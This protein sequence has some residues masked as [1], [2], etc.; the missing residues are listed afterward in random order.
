MSEEFNGVTV[1]G[2]QPWVHGVYA[3]G[4]SV[5]VVD[6]YLPDL[7]KIAMSGC[8]GSGCGGWSPSQ[9]NPKCK[10][11]CEELDDDEYC[12]KVSSEAQERACIKRKRASDGL[13]PVCGEKGRFVNFEMTCSKHGPYTCKEPEEGNTTFDGGDPPDEDVGDLSPKNYIPPGSYV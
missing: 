10:S 7:S 4:E 11:K 12:K 2:V 5:D 8:P 9:K 1:K 6:G 3:L 13:C